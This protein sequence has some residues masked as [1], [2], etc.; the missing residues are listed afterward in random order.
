MSETEGTLTL[1]RTSKSAIV[2]GG[3]DLQGVDVETTVAQYSGS[4]YVMGES[5]SVFGFHPYSD[6]E[7]PS[8]KAFL[9]LGSS[10]RMLNI[11]FDAETGISTISSVPNGKGRMYNLNGQQVDRPSR[12]VYVMDGKKLMIK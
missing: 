8:S 4:V 3:N 9:V 10:S 7:I 5:G 2:E 1:N 6:K 12:G 11:V